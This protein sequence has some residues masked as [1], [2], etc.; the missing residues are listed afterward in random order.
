ML[1]A[2]CRQL[3]SR[4]VQCP[5]VAPD[6]HASSAY[7]QSPQR[8]QRVLLQTRVYEVNHSSCAVKAFL[9]C[10]QPHMLCSAVPVYTACC[11]YLTHSLGQLYSYLAPAM[12]TLKSL[13]EMYEHHLKQGR[14][15]PTAPKFNAYY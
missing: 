4:L 11:K 10:Q 6:V 15:R 9:Y 3:Y 2:G 8:L 13:S 14:P 1:T 5:V 12:Q 7:I